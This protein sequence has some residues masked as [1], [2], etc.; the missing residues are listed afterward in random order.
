MSFSSLMSKDPRLA[1]YLSA[2]PPEDNLYTSSI[3]VGEVAYGLERLPRGRRHIRLEQSFKEVLK[4][5]RGV[6]SV[7][8]E[9]GFR[10][11]VLK[12]DLERRGKPIGKENDLWIAAI[13]LEYGMIL[14]TTQTSF[15]Y[16]SGL[17]IESWL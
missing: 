11:G 14:V 17:T 3:T 8:L 6:V 15:Q 10:Y 2:L 1:A 16:V 7:T 13:A 12:S 5:L 4:S 9:V